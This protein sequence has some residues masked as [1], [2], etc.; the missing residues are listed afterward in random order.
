MLTIGLAVVSVLVSNLV[1]T[2]AFLYICVIL[3]F[4]L[5]LGSLAVW[6]LCPRHTMQREQ[7]PIVE[8]FL[9]ALNLFLVKL[10]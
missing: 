1:L 9:L 7:A 10:T 2:F 4:L 3:A 6:H 5:C 8:P